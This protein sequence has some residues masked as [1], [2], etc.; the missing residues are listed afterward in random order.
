MPGKNVYTDEFIIDC[1]RRYMKEYGHKSSIKNWKEMFPDGPSHVMVS[2]HL[3]SWA[4]AIQLTDQPIKQ[5]TGSLLNTIGMLEKKLAIVE[6]YGQI[7]TDVVTSSLARFDTLKVDKPQPVDLEGHYEYANLLLSDAQIGTCFKLEDTAGKNLYNFDLFIKNCGILKSAVQ[8]IH[9]IH[10]H[11]YPV[12]RLNIWA[13]GDDVEGELIFTGQAFMIDK[14]LIDQVCEGAKEFAE[15]II[16]WAQ[17]IN[18]IHIYEVP[19][20]HGRIGKRGEGHPRTNWDTIFWRIVQLMVEKTNVTNVTFHLSM[21]SMLVAEVFGHNILLSHGAE[22]RGWMGIPFYGRHRDVMKLVNALELPIE[23]ALCGHHHNYASWDVAP[24]CEIVMNGS[25]IGGSPYS[26]R[27]L[28]TINSPKQ[29]MW[30]TSR[31]R[32]RTWTYPI[33]LHRIQK[34]VSDENGVYTPTMKEKK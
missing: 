32:V 1:V 15:M 23:L 10:A 3:G 22:T 27:E 31:R 4:K 20:N 8:T 5:D 29:V 33:E 28:K 6:D 16:Y 12:P 2:R 25:W 26:T 13:A 19:G 24:R 9:S 18:D 21:S 17:I 30:G 11:A 14:P 34:L 7:L